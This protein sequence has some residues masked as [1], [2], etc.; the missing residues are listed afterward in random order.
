MNYEEKI[1]VRIV[2]MSILNDLTIMEEPDQ[3]RRKAEFAKFLLL[4]HDSNQEVNIQKAWKEF[5][6]KYNF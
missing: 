2:V 3:K 6:H 5:D 1:K 4:N